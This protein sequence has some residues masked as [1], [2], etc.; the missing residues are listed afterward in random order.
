MIKIRKIILDMDNTLTD[1]ARAM[2]DY[3]IYKTGDKSRRYD[4]NKVSWN[5]SELIPW[6][7]EKV[8]NIFKD[9]KFFEFLKPFDDTIEAL[10]K[11]KELGFYLEVCSLQVQETLADKVNYIYNTF[12]MVDKITVL[13]LHNDIFDKS[14]IQGE[15]IVD[16]RIDILDNSPIK[17]KILV[18]SYQW[19]C[20]CKKY[21]RVENMTELVEYIMDCEGIL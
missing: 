16:D 4:K 3:Y 9:P 21:N 2:F 19:N 15:Y 17:N 20:D 6:D 13:P 11:L 18:G 14:E 8:N 7:K 12:P 5:M 1:T 10:N